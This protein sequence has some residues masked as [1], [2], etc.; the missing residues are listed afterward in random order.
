MKIAS[1]ITEEILSTVFRE[2]AVEKAL[3]LEY[4]IAYTANWYLGSDYVNC[5]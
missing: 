4:N 1:N 5:K 2:F 3:R